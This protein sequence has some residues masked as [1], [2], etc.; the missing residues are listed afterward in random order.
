MFFV[1]IFLALAAFASYIFP[2]WSWVTVLL[3]SFGCIA[4][5]RLIIHFSGRSTSASAK[6]E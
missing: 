3:V 6:G 4:A 5:F 2:D 1:I